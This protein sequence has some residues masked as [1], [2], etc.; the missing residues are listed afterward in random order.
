MKFSFIIPVYNGER[1][2]KKCID[3]IL[4]QNFLNT[5][6]IIINDGSTD[7]TD[8][9]INSAYH[10]DKRVIYKRI[11]NSG[12][13]AARNIGIENSTGEYIL[14]VDSDDWIEK[15]LL[16]ALNNL[17]EQ[18]NY[19]LILFNSYAVQN[20]IYPNGTD[21][22]YGELLPEN[23]LK[24][25]IGPYG[26]Y[27]S[28]P[29]LLN[30]YSTPWGKCYKTSVVKENNILFKN[31]EQIGGE[32]TFFNFEVFINI[33]SLYSLNYF[34][35]YYNKLNL[36]SLTSNYKPDRK[37]KWNYMHSRMY[38]VMKEFNLDKSF[39]NSLDNRIALS[40]IGLIITEAYKTNPKSTIQ[41]VK[42]ISRLINDK[43]YANAISDISLD[44]MPIHW[45]FYFLMAKMRF[46]I[47]LLFVSKIINIIREK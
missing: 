11:K 28:K 1:Y 7:N 42:S 36:E 10:S 39:F 19:D 25:H 37:E 27:L 13:S 8:K 43:I 38:A 5:E 40:I 47:G 4:E 15:D 31:R 18:K 16:I 17:L 44:N 46:A 21:L 23:L 30:Y 22:G 33:S 9:I 26:H 41:K 24:R 6:I 20:K 14:F 12:V 3:S 2:L 32:D 35:Y 29:H 34:G 45:K